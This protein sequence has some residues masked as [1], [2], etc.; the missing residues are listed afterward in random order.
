MYGSMVLSIFDRTYAE[1][2]FRL[3][4]DTLRTNGSMVRYVY[5]GFFFRSAGRKK[6]PP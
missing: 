1:D 2:R 5:G 3:P 4:F 6:N